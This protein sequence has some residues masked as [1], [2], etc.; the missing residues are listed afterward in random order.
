MFDKKINE[1]SEE[2]L[3]GIRILAE[4][5][6][7]TQPSLRLMVRQIEDEMKLRNIEP[8]AVGDGVIALKMQLEMVLK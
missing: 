3:R 7:V 5:L 2:E 4:N 8:D 1:M 6:S